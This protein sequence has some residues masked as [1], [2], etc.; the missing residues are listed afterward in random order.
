MQV[1]TFLHILS[2]FSAIT[3]IVGA[4]LLAITAIR[5]RDREMLRVYFRIGERA[6]IVGMVLLVLGIVFGLVA[7][8]TIGWDLL[9]GWLVIAYVL[10]VL[11]VVVGFSSAPYLARLKAALP[12]RDDETADPAL[13]ALLRS[14]RLPLTSAASI[15]LTA[16]LIADM[17]FKPT[18]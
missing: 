17:V 10:V 12:V 1:W 4:E 18:F 5:R 6:D 8:M 14:P 3:V 11:T 9:S 7:A 16:L 15:V 13:D 2:M